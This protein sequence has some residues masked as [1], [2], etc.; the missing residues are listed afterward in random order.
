MPRPARLIPAVLRERE[1]RLLWSGQLVSVVGDGMLL[2][3]LSFAVLDLT[4]SVTDLGVVLAVSRLPLL[5]TVL[6]GGVVADRL[7]RRWVMVGADLVRL[8]CQAACGALLLAG[9]AQLWQRA[10]VHTRRPE[11]LTAFGGTLPTL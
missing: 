2:V 5:L 8:G 3:A 7:P 9:R 10:S 6:A 4:G 11:R 1:F